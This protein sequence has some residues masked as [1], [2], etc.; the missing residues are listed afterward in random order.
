MGTAAYSRLPVLDTEYKFNSEPTLHPAAHGPRRTGGWRLR[1]PPTRHHHRFDG[2]GLWGETE[3]SRRA[4]AQPP[5]PSTSPLPRHS[6][7]SSLHPARRARRLG[8]PS[9]PPDGGGRRRRRAAAASWTPGQPKL[10]GEL[11]APDEVLS[12]CGWRDVARPLG[13]RSALVRLEIF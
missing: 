2:R 9:S 6:P 10:R 5:Q 7:P 1:H 11:G 8:A 4:T 12:A 13:A 3:L